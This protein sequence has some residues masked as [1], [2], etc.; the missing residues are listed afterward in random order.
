MSMEWNLQ[1]V[2]EPP[3]ELYLLFLIA[4]DKWM[5]VGGNNILKDIV[6]SS[7]WKCCFS[8]CF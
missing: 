8:L 5:V 1:Q 4:N 6:V 2:A 7:S 3:Y